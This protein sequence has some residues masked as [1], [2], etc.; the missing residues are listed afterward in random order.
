MF[1]MKVGRED[2]WS[3][4]VLPLSIVFLPENPCELEKS[5][6]LEVSER[7]S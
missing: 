2:T 1:L 3:I 7:F 6:P 5:E 4:D